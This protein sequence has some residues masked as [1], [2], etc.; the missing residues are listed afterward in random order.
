MKQI[1]I[2]VVG[3][4]SAF[5]A[6]AAAIALAMAPVQPELASGMPVA[7][8]PA[9][10]RAAR[11]ELAR[12][13]T[14]ARAAKGIAPPAV[15]AIDVPPRLRAA[16]QDAHSKEPLSTDA[17]TILALADARTNPTRA[18]V[19]FERIYALTKRDEAVVLW[20]AQRSARRNDVAGTLHYFDEVLRTSG[21]ARPLLLKQFALATRDPE[22]RASMTKLIAA[23][24]PWAGEFW[25]EA[26]QV[27]EAASSLARLRIALATTA[28]PFDKLADQRIANALV[29][30]GDYATALDLYRSAIGRAAR[31]TIVKNSDFDVQ[32]VMPP[33]DWE[34]YSTGDFGSEIPPDKGV[35][36]GYAAN[37]PGGVI[38]RQWVHLGPGQLRF[39]GVLRTYGRGEGDEIAATLTCLEDIA[40]G[41]TVQVFP[42]SQGQVET[43]FSRRG[44]CENYWLDIRIAPSERSSGIDV[45]FDSISITRIDQ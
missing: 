30:Q 39:R 37:S 4:T 26:S 21:Q 25:A 38:A 35:L 28:G 29:G 40:N 45:E 11:N 34:L 42:L 32:S 36:V 8:G 22:F 5:Y 33:V 41:N 18:A 1:A 7:N 2:A 13:S 44:G 12:I 27:P 31:A 14:K 16:A 19:L 24:P 9:I 15:F 43:I 10:A 3:A 20:L 23:R 6:C 17:L